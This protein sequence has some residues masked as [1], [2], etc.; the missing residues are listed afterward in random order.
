MELALYMIHVRWDKIYLHNLICLWRREIDGG[1]VG[2]IARNIFP[3][4]GITKKHFGEPDI[5]EQ[6]SRAVFY[7]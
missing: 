2:L 7:V 3:F 1:G 5:V 6:I 4:N